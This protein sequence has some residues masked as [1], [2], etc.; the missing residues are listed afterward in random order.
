M[1]LREGTRRLGGKINPDQSKESSLL[2]EIWLK[3]YQRHT[4]E[5]KYPILILRPQ[6]LK[7]RLELA[8][9]Q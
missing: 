5:G 7:M 8:K 4:S 9:S 2:Q 6:F 1:A 3:I